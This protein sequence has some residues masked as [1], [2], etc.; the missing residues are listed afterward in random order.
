MVCISLQSVCD[1]TSILQKP[2]SIWTIL[3]KAYLCLYYSK[4]NQV[5]NP[6][7]R[8]FLKIYSWD[9]HLKEEKNTTSTQTSLQSPFKQRPK[10]LCYLDIPQIQIWSLFIMEWWNAKINSWVEIFCWKTI[11]LSTDGKNLLLFAIN[12]VYF[13]FQQC[14]HTI[15][16][17]RTMV[18]WKPWQSYGSREQALC[19]KDV[20]FSFGS[21][22]ICIFPQSSR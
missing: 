21:Q 22:T 17:C 9:I 11:L 15:N 8:V 4:K 10:P 19:S 6:D 2:E 18:L 7:S 14:V 5:L 20:L 16:H 1:I 3:G 12:R 13:Q